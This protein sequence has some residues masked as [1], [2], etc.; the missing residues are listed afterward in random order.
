MTGK[1]ELT[2][3]ER[4]CTRSDATSESRSGYAD[5]GERKD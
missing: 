1:C 2:G 3:D 5:Q 4:R